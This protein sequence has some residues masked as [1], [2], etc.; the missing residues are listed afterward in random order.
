[1]KHLNLNLFLFEKLTQITHVS[2][3]DIGERL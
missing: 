2:I 3:A 1:M